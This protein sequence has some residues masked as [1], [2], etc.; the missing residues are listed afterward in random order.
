LIV[1]WY[2]P[3]ETLV[4]INKSA[5]LFIAGF[6]FS[7]FEDFQAILQRLKESLYGGL[8]LSGVRRTTGF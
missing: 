5:I 3:D 4:F 8:A 6:I 1:D 7:S 2:N